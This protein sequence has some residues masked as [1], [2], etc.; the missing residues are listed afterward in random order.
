MIPSFIQVA[1]TGTKNFRALCWVV[2]RRR[3]PLLQ[4]PLSSTPGRW[5]RNGGWGHGKVLAIHREETNIWERRAPL[6][7]NH[8]QSLVREGVK[9]SLL[10]SYSSAGTD[11]QLHVH[12]YTRDH[13][14]YVDWINYKAFVQLHMS[15]HVHVQ[16][17]PKLCGSTNVGD[18]QM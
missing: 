6:N 4:R 10:S 16:H 5:T 17:V 2:N 14:Y 13:L 18:N 11:C 8:V 12:T 15:C 3:A 9:V 7:P 1:R